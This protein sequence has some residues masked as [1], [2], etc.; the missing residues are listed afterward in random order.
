[1]FQIILLAIMVIAAALPFAGLTWAM[2]R[3]R[4]GLALTVISLIGAI[5]AILWF[6]SGRPIGIDP[7]Q[8]MTLA[9]IFG[10]PALLGGTAGVCLG[11]LLRKRDDA[12]IS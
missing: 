8:A 10:V 6:A 11:W 12:R 5:V 1:M 3:G 9:L 2:R 7:V 4:D